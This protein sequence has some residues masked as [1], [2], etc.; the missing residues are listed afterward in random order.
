MSSSLTAWL[1]PAGT[2]LD[3]PPSA[4]RE[5]T[6]L[7]A[8]DASGVRTGVGIGVRTLRVS[9]A[10]APGTGVGSALSSVEHPAAAGVTTNA[11]AAIARRTSTQA[12]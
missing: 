6:A 8:G 10:A 3:E 7:A 5:A 1:V 9:V 12:V 4:T 11:N 2:G